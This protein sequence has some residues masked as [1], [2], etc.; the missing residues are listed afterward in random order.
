M[1]LS[2]GDFSSNRFKAEN[3]TERTTIHVSEPDMIAISG[4]AGR[5]T[6]GDFVTLSNNLDQSSQIPNIESLKRM[7]IIDSKLEV[8]RSMQETSQILNQHES[9]M[10]QQRER[11]VS[12]VNT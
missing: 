11:S 7:A 12:T 4:Q 5:S 10:N 9:L 6:L 1:M 3:V 2:G 8:D